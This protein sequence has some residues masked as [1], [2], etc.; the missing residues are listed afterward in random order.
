MAT[1]M[2]PA[3]TPAATSSATTPVPSW[4]T[5]LHTVE[6]DVLRTEA[7]LTAVTTEGPEQARRAARLLTDEGADPGLPPLT[8]MPAL[9]TELLERVH[10]LRIRLAQVRTELEIAMRANRALLAETIAAPPVAQGAPRFF[11]T[12][13]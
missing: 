4:E 1:A 2:T 6:S 10:A 3:R 11:D 13:V 12:L 7:L 8:S 9:P 5:V